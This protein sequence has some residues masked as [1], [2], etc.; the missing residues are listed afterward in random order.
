[1]KVLTIYLK[2][3][4]FIYK[5]MQKISVFCTKIKNKCRIERK[6][7]KKRISNYSIYNADVNDDIPELISILIASSEELY[8]LI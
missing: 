6:K 5:E 4:R 8:P 3:C 1:M 7:I 2:I